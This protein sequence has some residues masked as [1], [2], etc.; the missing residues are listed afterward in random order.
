MLLKYKTHFIRLNQPLDENHKD[1][2]YSKTCVYAGFAVGS[3]DGRVA[4]DL[5]FPSNSDDIRSNVIYFFSIELFFL[6]LLWNLVKCCMELIST[7]FSTWGTSLVRNFLIK[8]CNTYYCR[9]MFRC[10]PKSIDRRYHQVAIN[11][12]IFDPR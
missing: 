4:L 2:F 10:H 6:V 5:A 1:I 12:I 7:A 9:Y 3:L 11:D 8:C